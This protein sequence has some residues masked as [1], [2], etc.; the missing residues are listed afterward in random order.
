[1]LCTFLEL[2]TLAQS[3]KYVT[4]LISLCT[5]FVYLCKNKHKF[6]LISTAL[7]KRI[8]IIFYVLH[9]L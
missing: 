1:M 6:P 8:F 7:Q 5:I 2:L 4:T 3:T 9:F